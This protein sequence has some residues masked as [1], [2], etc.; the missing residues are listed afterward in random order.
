MPLLAEISDK[1]PTVTGT[2]VAACLIAGVAIG[3]GLIRRWLVLLPL[4]IV[5][6]YNLSMWA[7]L[8]EPG[9]GG[10]IIRELGWSYVLGCFVGW[11]LPFPLA[12]GIVALRPRRYHEPGHCRHCG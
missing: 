9:F 12:M 8:H 7:E 1:M 2:T 5:V 3:L 6:L 4:P 10:A 11:N